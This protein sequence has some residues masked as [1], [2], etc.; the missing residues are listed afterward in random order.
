[1]NK[2]HSAVFDEASANIKKHQERYTKRY[3][4][5]HK[6]SE[7]VFGVSVGDKVQYV[8][9]RKKSRN[10]DKLK[11]TYLPPQGYVLVSSVNTR[12]NTCHLKNPETGEPLVHYHGKGVRSFNIDQFIPFIGTLE[13]KENVKKPQVKR[14][15]KRKRK[16]KKKNVEKESNVL[17]KR[18]VTTRN[19]RK[20][21]MLTLN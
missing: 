15:K 9:G 1:M 7:N 20:T 5:R 17:K 10:G 4:A 12:T 6:V 19:G 18:K 11:T 16:I 21:T 3:N 13:I 2:I 8:N 14:G